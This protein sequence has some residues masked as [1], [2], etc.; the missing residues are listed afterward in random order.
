MQ[1]NF[2]ITK[3]VDIYGCNCTTENLLILNWVC[4]K[5]A[6]TF[7]CCLWLHYGAVFENANNVVIY[8]RKQIA[9]TSVV[10]DFFLWTYRN[11]AECVYELLDWPSRN[12]CQQR[13]QG[14]SISCLLHL[15]MCSLQIIRMCLLVQPTLSN[16]TSHNGTK[17]RNKQIILISNE[18]IVMENDEKFWKTYRLYRPNSKHCWN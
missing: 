13:A 1:C 15:V 14:I 6:I 3:A 8:I 9:F 2:S 18:F 5:L 12:R 4:A 10:Y 17:K 11:W 16:S 7:V